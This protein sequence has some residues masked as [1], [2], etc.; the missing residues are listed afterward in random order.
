[1]TLEDDLRSA[2]HHH[3][4][5]VEPSAGGLE[6]IEA[7]L[8]GPAVQ[9]PR[10]APRLL[11]AAAVL[12]AIG[13]VGALTFRSNGD[14]N[15]EVAVS[16]S[17]SDPAAAAVVNDLEP[18]DLDGENESSGGNASSTVTDATPDI[19]QWNI[20]LAPTGVLGPRE[21]SPEKAVE[22][23]LGLIQ[24][25]AEEVMIDIQDDLARVSR[26]SEGGDV[27][28]V[29]TMQLGSVVTSDGATEYVVI[30]AISPRIVIESPSL[31]S[32]TTAP[33]LA[34]AGQGEGFEA[35]VGLD[36]YSSD[37][38]VWL[39]RGFV[40]AGN[41]GVMGPFSTELAVSGSGPAW[42]V[43]QSSGGT[44]TALD[45]FSA[46][47]VVIDAPLQTPDY[48]VTNI[49]A[50][51]PDGGLVVRTLPGTDGVELA[52]LPSGQSVNKRS[53]LSA[54]IGDGEPS[55]EPGPAAEGEQ[56][57]WNIWLPEPLEGGRQWG[58]VNSR[59]LEDASVIADASTD[60][61]PLE[62]IGSQF[63][64]GL[65]GDDAAF[66]QLPWSA[67]GVTVGLTSDLR[68]VPPASL[69]DGSFW[70]ATA[71]WILPEAYGGTKD[72][73]G[74]ELMSPTQELL[75]A[76]NVSLR[77][78]TSTT[79]ASPFGNDQDLFATQFPGASYV[80]VFDPTRDSGWV[81]INIF[82]NEGA[83]GLEVI[84]VVA[85]PWTP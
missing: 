50:D 73:T 56:E 26:V 57:W 20:P 53:A 12:V 23:F 6:R 75:G 2:L 52:V 15:I 83:D 4:E 16:S 45:P 80:Q 29:T 40:S 41:F 24:R 47:P 65:R 74:R 19:T 33:V 67:D 13:T 10:L 21:A 68:I 49:P 18:L 25:G 78:D 8:A 44:D 71:T 72:L 77:S 82:V 63:V 84:G 61:S 69:A 14:S 30:Q 58:W 81:L 5:Q 60:A 46:V 54:L 39:N 38:G 59:Y 1:M 9:R 3:A 32:T 79:T 76:T 51:D 64:L 85:T 62:A 35:T 27:V 7:R 70:S 31:L 42:L 48:V 11:A 37:D 17:T 36:L 66:A 22:S 34:V 55:Y 28:G 43:V